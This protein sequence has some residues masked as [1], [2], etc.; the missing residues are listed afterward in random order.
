[1]NL[2][3]LKYFFVVAKERGFTNASKLLRIQQPA[4]SRMV[5][6]LEDD[7]GFPLFERVGRSVQLTEPGL[8]VFDYCKKIFAT[9]DELEQSLGRIG[10]ECKGPLRVAASEPIASHLLPHAIKSLLERHPL[11][12]PNLFSGPAAMMFERIIQGE[13]EFGAFFHIPDLPDK[14]EIFERREIQFHLVIAKTHRRDKSICETFIGSREIDDSSTRRFPT[15]ERLRRDFPK[16]QIRI[17][18]NNLTAHREMVLKGLGVSVLPQFLVEADLKTGRLVDLYPGEMLRFQLKLVK[19]RTS[20]L[21]LAA[22][23]LVGEIER[24]TE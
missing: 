1:M 6:Q 12:Y 21:S 10:G 5:R 16:A 4:I 13:I 19:R 23:Q 22:T 7:F 11:V 9:V 15:L 2:L 24:Q 14:L 20:V 18:S 8:E 17:S 3:H